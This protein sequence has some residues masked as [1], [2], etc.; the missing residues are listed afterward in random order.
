MKEL[1]E[2]DGLGTTYAK[3][4]AEAGV[5]TANMLAVQD[6]IEL[7]ERTKIADGTVRKHIAA[8]RALLKLDIFRP[9]TEIEKE[10]KQVPR[11]TFG[12]PELDKSLRG[13][14]ELGTKVEFY[15]PASSG[16]TQW[17]AHLA[18]RVVLDKELGGLEGRVFWLDCESSFKPHVLRANIRRWKLEYWKKLPEE[19]RPKNI[20]AALKEWD[21]NSYLD[22]ILSA[23]FYI[24]EQQLEFLENLPAMIHNQRVKLVI[25]DSFSGLFRQEYDG[26]GEL[27]PRQGIFNKLLNLMRKAALGTECIFFYTNQVM[28]KFGGNVSIPNSPIGGHILS[29]GSDYRFRLKGGSSVSAPTK[30]GVRLMDN[31]GLAD[32]EHTIVIGTGGFYSDQAERN[33]YEPLLNELAF[34]DGWL[35]PKGTD[36]ERQLEELSVP[37]KEEAKAGDTT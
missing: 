12:L 7:S 5:L 30:R 6:P 34:E 1:T 2:V 23:S 18:S 17:A 19:D 3:K 25:I 27:R 21:V 24:S 20:K 9:A 4:Y 22:N 37:A 16:K 13:G 28:D 32:I 15:G 36:A 10:Q 29:H 35:P 8:A 33:E 11:L 14:I 31:A 26:L